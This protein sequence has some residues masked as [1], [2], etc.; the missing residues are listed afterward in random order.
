MRTTVKQK[1]NDELMMKL[2]KNIRKYR[3]LR[4]ITQEELADKMEISREYLRRFETKFGKE[5]LSFINIYKAAK[6][7]NVKIDDLVE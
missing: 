2:A 6:V 3:K 5:G 7:L 1:E 4:N